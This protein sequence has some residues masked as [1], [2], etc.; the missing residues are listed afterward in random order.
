MEW[1]ANTQLVVK[2]F[3]PHR[4]T[5][6]WSTLSRLQN[7]EQ[8]E[9]LISLPDGFTVERWRLSEA[10]KREVANRP[11]IVDVI[12]EGYGEKPMPVGNVPQEVSVTLEEAVKWHGVY[13]LHN[14]GAKG[15]GQVI[16]VLDTGI[17]RDLHKTLASQGRMVGAVSFIDGE[18]PW[19]EG[20]ESGHGTF[21]CEAVATMAPEARILAIKVLS[22]REGWGSTS[23]IIK[24][25]SYARQN[26]AT[27]ITASLG[28]PGEPGDAMCRTV[29]A[30][31]RAG[32]LCV[33]AA[34]NE[35]RGSFAYQADKSHPGCAEES[36]TVAAFDSDKD[37]AD[38]SNWGKCV[39]LGGLGVRLFQG[40][41]EWS[42][43]SMATPIVAGIAACVR[44]HSPTSPLDVAAAKK[45]LYASALDTEYD[46]FKEGYGLLDGEIIAERLGLA[47]SLAPYCPD[48]PRIS[49][50]RL[51]AG[52]D[53]ANAV[54]TKRRREI[55]AYMPKP[56]A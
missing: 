52:A 47:A 55:G 35:Q 22:S 56:E 4:L 51:A 20:Q 38:F 5:A 7:E 23:S 19:D 33:S 14:A 39:K 25:Y 50:T 3:Q 37:L 9:V 15:K 1:P 16:A 32:H 24:G 11:H 43:T 54:L 12:E 34:G 36:V 8:R 48:W 28:G 53:D 49:V 41:R 27:V 45:T 31:S 21:C 44:G 13:H 46:V 18:E 42:G 17:S 2:R 29:D 30:L 26:G 40:G 10:E 6:Y